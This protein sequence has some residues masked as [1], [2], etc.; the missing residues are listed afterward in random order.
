VDKVRRAL[1]P[2]GMVVVEGFPKQSVPW[3]F[4][5]GELAALFKDGFTVMRD[6]VVDDVSDW[7]NSTPEKLVRFAAM[8]N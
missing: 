8:K 1:K 4:D 3:G 5:S 6:E 7:G 2:G